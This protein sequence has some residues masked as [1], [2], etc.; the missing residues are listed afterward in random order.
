MQRLSTTF[1]SILF[2]QLLGISDNLTDCGSS[3]IKLES[4]V[5]SMVEP[6]SGF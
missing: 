1:R 3:L 5:D 6:E 4:A 2:N